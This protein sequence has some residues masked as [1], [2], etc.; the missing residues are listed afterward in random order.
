MSVE[1]LWTQRTETRG[2]REKCVERDERERNGR[3]RER[4]RERKGY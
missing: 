4:E 3:E 2:E 1:V